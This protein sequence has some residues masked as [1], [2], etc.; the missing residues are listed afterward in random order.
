LPSTPAGLQFNVA[1]QQ[2]APQGQQT[3]QVAPA[4]QNTNGERRLRNRYLDAVR[5]SILGVHLATPERAFPRCLACCGMHV[6]RFILISLAHI[7]SL[8]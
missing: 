8:V 7:L 3:Q 4:C 1:Q 2:P 5:D 6:V